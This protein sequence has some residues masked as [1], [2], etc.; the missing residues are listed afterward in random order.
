M[1]PADLERAGDLQRLV[2]I[3]QGEGTAQ[4]GD[5]NVVAQIDA[6]G[7]QAQRGLLDRPEGVAVAI[8]PADVAA[9]FGLDPRANLGA[10]RRD[11]I[12]LCGEAPKEVASQ[13]ATGGYRLGPGAG[14]PAGRAQ[15][16]AE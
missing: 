4:I 3:G 6:A 9:E 11:E 10:R 13:F 1:L 16:S 14:R 7:I 5:M 15:Q 8:E 12:A 2:Q